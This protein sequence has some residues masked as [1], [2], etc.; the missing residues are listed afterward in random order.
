LPS[1]KTML[2]VLGKQKKKET[3]P[4]PTVEHSEANDVAE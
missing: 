1:F 3:V 4:M 2:A